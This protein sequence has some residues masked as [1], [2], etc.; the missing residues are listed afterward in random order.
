MRAVRFW[1]LSNQEPTSVEAYIK[2]ASQG[3][4]TAKEE[5][6]HHRRMIEEASSCLQALLLLFEEW[7][8]LTANAQKRQVR[9]KNPQKPD[10]FRDVIN[11]DWIVSA[12]WCRNTKGILE[13]YRWMPQ[14]TAKEVGESLVRINQAIFR[15][16]FTAARMEA[17]NTLIKNAEEKAM[18]KTL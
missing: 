13:C 2:R 9:G 18:G 15:L 5:D 10:C 11:R 17:N 3:K 12:L 7:K 14:G 6:Y 4:L 16:G 1:L 8:L